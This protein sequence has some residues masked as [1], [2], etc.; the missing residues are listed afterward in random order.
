MEPT[1]LHFQTLVSGDP[2]FKS[3]QMPPY[4][5]YDATR[6]EILSTSGGSEAPAA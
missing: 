3:L 2:D 1:V 6:Y 5:R 4:T